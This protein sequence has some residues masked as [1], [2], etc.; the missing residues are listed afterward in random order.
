MQ[1]KR[2]FGYLDKELVEQLPSF[3]IEEIDSTH[4]FV[5]ARLKGFSVLT[6]LKLLYPLK[7]HRDLSFSE[8]Y[9]CSGIRMKSS[10]LNYLNFCKEFE[11][12]TRKAIKKRFKQKGDSIVE[13][14]IT[15]KG[16]QFMA[17]FFKKQEVQ[18]VSTST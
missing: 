6:L 13:Y 12:V 18:I 14:N 1:L 4:Y 16:R 15:D 10:F 3:V 17:L 8:L 11:F 9:Y 5:L 7:K 2:R